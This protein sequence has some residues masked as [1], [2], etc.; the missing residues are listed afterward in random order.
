MVSENA[1]Y[2][3]NKLTY[4][5]MVSENVNYITNK[6]TYDDLNI[7]CQSYEDNVSGRFEKRKHEWVS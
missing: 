2:I 1:N 7:V 3:T 5:V 6:L 4:K